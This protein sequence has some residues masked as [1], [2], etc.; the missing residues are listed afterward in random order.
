MEREREL[1]VPVPLA[2]PTPRSI[3]VSS[4]FTEA[5]RSVVQSGCRAIS[6]SQ[7]VV[8]ATTNAVHPSGTAPTDYSWSSASSSLSLLLPLFFS[9][10]PPTKGEKPVAKREEESGILSIQMMMWTNAN[11]PASSFY[12][13]YPLPQ[14][15]IFAEVQPRYFDFSS[16]RCYCGFLSAPCDKCIAFSC[17]V[18]LK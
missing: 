15:W 18:G 16:L 1:L 7:P 5:A 4:P 10:T 11:P 9:Y 12:L 2:K 17:A 13:L 6:S 8:M 14:L 3:A